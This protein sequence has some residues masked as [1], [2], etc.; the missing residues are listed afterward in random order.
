VVVDE[1]VGLGNGRMLP[2][3]PLRES[4]LA[5]RRAQ[6]LV[7]TRCNLGHSTR[8]ILGRIKRFAPQLVVFHT[9][10]VAEALAPLRQDQEPLTIKELRG[11]SIGA[12]CGLG[13][14]DSFRK[15]LEETGARLVARRAFPDHHRPFREELD[16]WLE[17]ARESG[18]RWVF[19]TEKDRENLP[20][21]WSPTLPLYVLRAR[22]DWG[23][24]AERFRAFLMRYL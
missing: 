16:V 7:F 4:L 24:D 6:A 20:P 2:R 11:Q 23:E 12:F 21:D 10:L 22:V 19:L 3:G 8:R 5:L 18:A 15:L 14:P 1:A 17:Q 13:N 9:N